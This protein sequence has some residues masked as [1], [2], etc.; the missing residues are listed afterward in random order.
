MRSDWET[1]GFK[2]DHWSERERSCSSLK[3]KILDPS[4]IE[5]LTPGC[6]PGVLP[7][8]LQAHVPAIERKRSAAM[9]Q[10]EEK[11]TPPEPSPLCERGQRRRRVLWGFGLMQNPHMKARRSRV[12]KTT[13]ETRRPRRVSA[14]VFR[15]VE[16]VSV[17]S[18]RWSRQ[19]GSKVGAITLIG[20][21]RAVRRAHR[22][23]RRTQFATD[24]PRSG[25]VR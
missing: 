4:G 6:K 9:Q 15:K 18:S 5:P 22:H 25:H 7:L 12:F 1:T 16:R 17:R 24:T 13:P 23:Q 20:S 21:F 2:A 10:P 8:A 11:E 3:H 14:G 19:I